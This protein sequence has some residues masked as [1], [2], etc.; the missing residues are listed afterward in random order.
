MDYSKVLGS[1][2]E[3]L[4]QNV[5]KWSF[6]KADGRQEYPLTRFIALARIIQGIRE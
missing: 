4:V 5:V 2:D 1:F 3:R 6:V